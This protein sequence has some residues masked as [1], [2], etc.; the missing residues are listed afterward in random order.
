MIHSNSA[1]IAGSLRAPDLLAMLLLILFPIPLHAADIEYLPGGPLAG[2]TLPKLPAPA[3]V[4][5]GYAYE[6][7]HP[8]WQLS[9]GSVEHW[10][11]YWMKYCPVRSMFDAGTQIRRFAAADLAKSVNASAE[12][13]SA[14]VYFVSK[15]GPNL[16]DITQ[17]PV[18]VL[19]FAVAG[20][21]LNLDLGELDRGVY[22]LRIIAA[23]PTSELTPIRKP[24]FVR[25]SVND[26]PDGKST[27]CRQRIN[28]CD[29]FYCV[30]ELYFHASERRRYNIQLNV[31]ADSEIGLLVHEI[32]IDD[33]LAGRVRRPIKTRR[34]LDGHA[35]PQ[36]R[37]TSAYTSEDRLARDQAIWRLFPPI[38]SQGAG[39]PFKMSQPT[40]MFANEI[41]VGLPGMTPQQIEEQYGIWREPRN[42]RNGEHLYSDPQWRDV[43]IHNDKLGI[44]YTIDDLL[45]RRPL[46]DPYP[47]K[48]TGDGL[49]VPDPN[50]PNRAFAWC[51]IGDMIQSRYAW[52]PVNFIASRT[53]MWLEKGDVDAAH[54]AA[55]Y[56]IR[57][58][59]A[60]PTLDSASNLANVVG[61]AMYGRDRFRFRQTECYFFGHFAYYQWLAECYDGLFTFIKDNQQLADSVHRF[62]P[63][64][65][66]PQDVIE[67]IDVY[68]IQSSAKRILRYHDYTY[69]SAIATMATCLADPEVTDPWMQWLFA[70]TFYYPMA[71]AGVQDSM[72]SGTSPEGTNYGNG[73]S[74]HYCAG[75]GASFMIAPVQ[76]YIEATGDKRYD[77]TDPGR[78][79]RPLAHCYWHLNA[80]VA[81]WDFL[82]IGNVTGS[83]KLP[84]FMQLHLSHVTRNGWRWSRDPV[85]AFLLKNYEGRA[86]ESDDEWRDIETAAANMKR[87]PW[88]DQY[89]RVLPNWAAVLETGHQHDDPR[90]RRAAYIRTGTGYGH[91]HEDSLDLQIVAHGLPMTIDG[92]QRPGYSSPTDGM[93]RLHNLVELGG[94][95]HRGYAWTTVLTDH[96]GFR[97]VS[98]ATRGENAGQHRLRQVALIDVDEGAGSTPLTIDQQL[99]GAKLPTNVVTPNSYIFDCF[100]ADDRTVHTWCFHA[101][102]NDDFTWNA[103]DEQP[104]RTPTPDEKVDDLSPEGYLA[105]FTRN[106][107]SKFVGAAPDTLIATWRASRDPQGVGSEPYML[108]ANF[109]PDSP[110]KFTRVHL[111]DVE[112]DRTLRADAVTDR[113]G[114]AKTHVFV[115]R[116]GEPDRKLNTT[117]TSI[118]EPYAGQ[119]FIESV[120]SL[121]VTPE[122]ADFTR[123]VAAQVRLKNGRQDICF[124]GRP[125]DRHLRSIAD[126]SIRVNA[127]AAIYSTDDA[128]LVALALTG[129]KQFHSPLIRLEPAA[130]RMEATIVNIDFVGRTLTIDKPW[131]AS[132]SPRVMTVRSRDHDATITAESVTPTG[133]GAI[134]HARY[135]AQMYRC[136]V[137]EWNPEQSTLRC[138]LQPWSSWVPNSPGEWIAGDDAGRKFFRVRSQGGGSWK[139]LD[140]IPTPEDLAPSGSLNVWWYAPGDK[141]TAVTSVFVRRINPDTFSL[142][143]DIDARI[144]LPGKSA[145][146]SA[147]AG[148]SWASVHGEVDQ[149]WITLNILAADQPTLLRISP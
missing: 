32:S 109:N 55:L 121:T 9:P 15:R 63:W 118:I 136:P 14:P 112:G 145:Q 75:E 78:F 64:V 133:E 45:N 47:Y 100:R 88:L 2:I 132:A 95:D 37:T 68:G 134:L 104:V 108:K 117:F 40:V 72:I 33:A 4:A 36:S 61:P 60:L 146:I 143:C 20:P 107:E 41:T 144:A 106:R 53:R 140:E 19:R 71:L 116:I 113:V 127:E 131:R 130:D 139:F 94:R 50:D 16:S 65:H 87:A 10:R 67:L 84:G 141:I 62:V 81:G 115:Q 51:P 35:D 110:P 12:S 49:I 52:H 66:T 77:L 48:D 8:E 1:S 137:N 120:R 76:Q 82:R 7:Q 138:G 105:K 135:T 23:V 129:G 27:T 142:Q 54:D 80:I 126:A 101:M 3:G 73:G 44:S 147:D 43:L 111:L 92:G 39:K 26:Q 29:E 102:V 114:Y 28:Y 6:G 122:V 124:A 83:D 58:A 70:R 98:A 123:P 18:D 11:A 22:V 57:Y 86:G 148:Q 90:F 89:S 85:F 56:V 125:D 42:P 103:S 74:S 5:V 59:Y 17:P 38:N 24:L 46:P 93:T 91:Q 30:A 69:P 31:D 96:P 13:F 97:Y 128:G 34:T 99:P 119:P 79:P 25:M 21:A 149:G